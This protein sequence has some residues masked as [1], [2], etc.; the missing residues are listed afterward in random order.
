MDAVVLM[1]DALFPGCSI[2]C[3]ILGVLETEDERGMVPKLILCP[4]SKIDPT[5]EHWNDI[6]DV[7]LPILNKINY[8]FS[9]Y[10]D[11]EKGTFVRVRHLLGKK[12]ARQMVIESR[13][14]YYTQLIDEG[15]LLFKQKSEKS[16]GKI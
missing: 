4:T 9:H 5:Y 11:L 3:R 15:K 8:F 2:Q 16:I 6:I 12:D 7:S 1:E 14:R 13:M 10:K